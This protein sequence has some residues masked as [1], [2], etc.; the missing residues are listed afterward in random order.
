MST[1]VSRIL[2]ARE[3]PPLTGMEF[4][5]AQWAMLSRRKRIA[6]HTLWGTQLVWLMAFCAAPDA[7]AQGASSLL[8]FT[9]IPD[10]AGVPV[11]R[12][13]AISQDTSI[14]DWNG[15]LP[16]L[17]AGNVID[18]SF[19]NAVAGAAVTMVKI[20]FCLGAWLFHVARSVVFNQIF[21]TIFK[22]IGYSFHTAL[23]SAPFLLMAL[24]L[25]TFI[26]IV[27]MS[28]GRLA[29]G[30]ATIALSW[31]FGIPG[32]VFGRNAM[33]DLLEPGGWIDNVRTVADGFATTLMRNGHAISTQS[34]GLD[35]TFNTME[36]AL[37]DGVVRFPMM[38]WLLGRPVRGKVP[39]M[40]TGPLE[41]AGIGRT[42]A[43]CATAWDAGQM[44]GSRGKLTE[45]LQNACPADIVEHMANV[46][47]WEGWALPILGGLILG[48]GVWWAICALNCLFRTLFYGAFAEG[49]ILLAIVPGW[50]RRFAQYVGMDAVSQIVSYALYTV[51]TSIYVL[52]LGVCFSLSYK[53][54]GADY[55]ILKL[56][57]TATVM[58]MFMSQLKRL[59]RMYRAAMGGAGEALGSAMKAAKA[60]AG[61]VGAGAALGL[62]GA[63]AFGAASRAG[64]VGASAGGQVSN[65]NTQSRMS[66]G[67]QA[68]IG[69]AATAM[70]RMHPVAAA[71]GAVGGGFGA[72]GASFFR[73][74]G[75]QGT[76]GG[77]GAKNAVGVGRDG[78]AGIP[79]P[80]GGQGG[81]GSSAQQ[82]AHSLRV[83]QE[84]ADRV[85]GLTR[86]APS[87]RQGSGDGPA[88]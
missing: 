56:V 38:V 16:R 61:A 84:A 54:W 51:M 36:I 31:L 14:A 42:D 8:D 5:A 67:I 2:Y 9:G 13:M 66:A 74:G 29:A 25:G 7:M 21:G 24:G 34:T 60:V 35:R 20:I 68:G 50:L 27:M 4:L 41:A 76:S 44:S 62:S 73:P 58:V 65:A 88:A 82:Q 85:R 17:H 57:I 63:S 70:S 47:P 75:G 12:N 78:S 33:S 48:V 18:G 53:Q 37:A 43:T 87:P 46:N 81:Q 55:T 49:F 6:I 28:T 30:R 79:G 86:P 11:S 83:D 77:D 71:A 72:A 69:A 15:T 32:M 23:N 80:R 10:S 22:S 64:G 59:G 19:D 52:V 3:V 39:N 26:G 1:T 40:P 45:G